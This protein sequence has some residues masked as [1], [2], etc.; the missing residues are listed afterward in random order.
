MQNFT[1]ECINYVCLYCLDFNKDID[2]FHITSHVP[3]N[4]ICMNYGK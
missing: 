1:C 3:G 2:I 4:L